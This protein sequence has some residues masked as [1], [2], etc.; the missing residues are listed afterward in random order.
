M[1]SQTREDIEYIVKRNKYALQD[2]LFVSNK[3][4][5][6]HKESKSAY[7]ICQDSF[8]IKN[9]KSKEILQNIKRSIYIPEAYNTNKM[10]LEN[11]PNAQI[12]EI[13]IKDKFSSNYFHFEIDSI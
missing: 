9:L 7:D 6:Y 11:I 8:H 3:I 2:S 12:K 10:G 4:F 5:K 1:H 13:Q